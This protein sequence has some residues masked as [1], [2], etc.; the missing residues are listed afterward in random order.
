MLSRLLRS[1]LTKAVLVIATVAACGGDS[2]P[3][4]PSTPPPSQTPAISLTLAVDSVSVFKGDTVTVLVTLA[5][6]GGFTGAV[7]LEVSGVPTGVTVDPGDLG[8]GN[9]TVLTIVADGGAADVAG[10][11]ARVVDDHGHH[12]REVAD[13]RVDRAAT[14]LAR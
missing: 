3:T 11:V 10:L 5:R 6:S 7:A 1:Q 2:G 4:S 8:T 13:A 12:R 9:S 14:D